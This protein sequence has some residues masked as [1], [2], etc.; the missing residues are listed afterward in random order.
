MGW[1][2]N[3]QISKLMTQCKELNYSINEKTAR[4][5]LSKHRYNIEASIAEL[6]AVKQRPPVHS[7]G[8]KDPRQDDDDDDDNDDNDESKD[9]ISRLIRI[10]RSTILGLFL[11]LV[12]QI[13][14]A[15]LEWGLVFFLVAAFFWMIYSMKGGIRKPGQLSAYSLLNP[16]CQ[17]LPGS[18]E[19]SLKGFFDQFNFQKRYNNQD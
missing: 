16:N 13:F 2:E 17:A 8:A 10:N 18:Y 4:K 1:W 6:G 3:E 12:L 11:T 7:L 15:S 9:S 19:E 5:V 14:F